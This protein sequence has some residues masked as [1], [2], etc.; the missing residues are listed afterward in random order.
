MATDTNKAL[1]SAKAALSDA[2]NFTHSVTGGKPSAFKPKADKPADSN[3]SHV[4]TARAN[5]D[6]G[7]EAESAAAGLKANA[8][9]V[10]QYVAA[11][12]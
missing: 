5:S 11:T 12:Q 6:I 8:D 3:Y 2:S 4:R 7:T 10:K 9:N 1:E